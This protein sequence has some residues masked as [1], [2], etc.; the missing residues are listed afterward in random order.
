MR[1][2][3]RRVITAALVAAVLAAAPA[4]PTGSALGA[5]PAPSVAA[6]PTIPSQQKVDAAKSK[7][8][9]AAQ[10]VAALQR[11]LSAASGRLVTLGAALAQA[12]EQY[13]AALYQ[14]DQAQAKSQSASQAADAA[15]QQ[16]GTAQT[17]L[18]RF[19]SAAYRSGGDLAQVDAMLGARG[20]QDLMDQATTMDLLGD[21]Q[22]G[23]LNRVEA[24]R[25]TAI[26]LQSQ[27][28]QALAEQQAAADEVKTS[29]DK[30]QAMVT[31]QQRL[32][33]DLNAQRTSLAAQV[34]ALRST[35][36]RLAA[37]R[38]S[39]L[40]AAAADRAASEEA[41][42]G[43]SAGIPRGILLGMP[44]NV[45]VGQQR[46][47]AT[48]AK[49]AV[50]YARKQIGKP[51]LWAA[52]GPSRFDCSGLTM[53]GWREGGVGL[54]HWSVAQYA[55]GKKISLGQLRPGDLVFFSTDLSEYRAIVHVAMYIGGG[56]MIEAPYT[57][58]NVRISSINRKSL[59]GAVRP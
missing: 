50:E 18:S 49:L 24:A 35:S 45:P 33:D 15:Q 28:L 6:D 38:A 16:L 37:Q 31:E 29:R 19:A 10:R 4:I 34:S 48:G 54:A 55:A 59:F 3:Q 36:E 56:Q 1:Q 17:D 42:S 44:A 57:G 43:D 7:A 20:P 41:P 21:R 14:R 53:M 52:A 40:A 25:A 46:S 9:A 47:T 12:S 22:A 13:N 32:A 26:V 51:Y 23:A 30:A 39:G 27:A 58:A 5:G 2:R 8:S 11:Q